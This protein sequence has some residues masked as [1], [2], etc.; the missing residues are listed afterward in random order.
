[1]SQ[2]RSTSAKRRLSNEGFPL[3]ETKSEERKRLASS[4]A[5]EQ[6][7]YSTIHGTR[8]IPIIGP[9]RSL[10]ARRSLDEHP[11]H[12]RPAE[13]LGRM[14]GPR[15]I[16]DVRIQPPKSDYHLPDPFVESRQRAPVPNV[17]GRDNES[18]MLL[19]VGGLFAGS[20]AS[21]KGSLK[22][23]ATTM[24]SSLSPRGSAHCTSSLLDPS[25]NARGQRSSKEELEDWLAKAR[26]DTARAK[27]IDD[28]KKPAETQYYKIENIPL[29]TLSSAGNT[30]QQSSRGTFCSSNR[31]WKVLLLTKD[32]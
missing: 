13:K 9:S 28:T 3:R 19:G 12:G 17:P 32:I 26:T 10:R 11:K 15:D 4:E 29:R 18:R 27:A 5:T 1:M 7:D 6:D 14:Y 31:E 16:F 21:R 23:R 30:R 20:A 25:D 22:S 8:P 24:E 2:N